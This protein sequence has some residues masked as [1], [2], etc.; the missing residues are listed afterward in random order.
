MSKSNPAVSAQA[1]F[2][3]EAL[4]KTPPTGTAGPAPEIANPWSDTPDSALSAT[5]TPAP[6]KG[7]TPQ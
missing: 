5:P 3:R 2:V 7:V 4:E 1:K 6:R